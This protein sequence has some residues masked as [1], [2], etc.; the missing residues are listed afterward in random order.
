MSFNDPYSGC[1]PIPQEVQPGQEPRY[2]AE[3]WWQLGN[4]HF[5]QLDAALAKILPRN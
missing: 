2:V 5:D 4:F 3:A 1:E